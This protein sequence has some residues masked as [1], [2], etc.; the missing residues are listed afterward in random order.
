MLN[1]TGVLG[2][3]GR[4]DDHSGL[5]DLLC[6]PVLDPMRAAHLQHVEDLLAKARKEPS[7]RM[8]TRNKHYVSLRTVASGAVARNAAANLWNPHA[9]S[10][11]FLYEWWLFSAAATASNPALARTTARGT[12]STTLAMA[13]GNSIENDTASPSGTVVDSAWSVAPTVAAA[14]NGQANIA[15][16]I[17]NGVVIALSDPLTIPA[18]AGAAIITTQ[19]VTIPASDLT[20]VFGD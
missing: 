13:A 14:N 17:G 11:I 5:R 18:V 16:T 9:S 6:T 20:F 8:Y 2:Y 12:A 10:R 1:T 15:A 19:A 7:F 4:L 3:V